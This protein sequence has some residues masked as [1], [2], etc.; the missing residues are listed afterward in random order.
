MNIYT[1][2]ARA[3][4]SLFPATPAVCPVPQPIRVVKQPTR[5]GQMGR[6]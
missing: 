5:P 1:L 6:R 2:I 4:A 3:F